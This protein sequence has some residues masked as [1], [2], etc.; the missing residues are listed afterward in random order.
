MP[1]ADLVKALED[2]LFHLREV[3]G[4]NTFPKSALD[5]LNDWAAQEKGWLR[6]FYRQDGETNSS[7][8]RSIT[9]NNTS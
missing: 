6:K 9:K 7:R 3:L 1:Q 8:H 4:E 5:Y 2:E